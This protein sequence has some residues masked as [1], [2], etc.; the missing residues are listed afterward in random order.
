MRSF[1]FSTLFF[2]SSVSYGQG[3]LQFNQVLS[4]SITVG[5]Q[6]P[7][8]IITSAITVPSG[9]VWKVESSSFSRVEPTIPGYRLTIWGG[10]T[11]QTF[12]LD[13]YT[14]CTYLAPSIGFIEPKFP[15]WLSEG[16]HTL[17]MINHSSSSNAS[18]AT[19]TLSVIEFNII[20]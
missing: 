4:P 6:P 17:R 16:T 7:G 3:N 13:D 15:I 11:N 12:Y 1:L 2:L 9:K 14:V 18:P 20:P 5:I 19:G 10:T 8:Q